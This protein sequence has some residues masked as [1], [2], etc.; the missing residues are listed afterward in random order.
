M[1][2]FFLLSGFAFHLSNKDEFI[3]RKASRI[4]IPYFICS[5]IYWM[6]IERFLRPADVSL[7]NP[8]LFCLIMTGE[9]I[10]TYYIED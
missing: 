4:L 10:I 2:L 8:R 3:K 6:F 7:I 5:F 9:S 1:P